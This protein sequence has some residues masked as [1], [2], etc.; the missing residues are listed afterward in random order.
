MTLYQPASLD[1]LRDAVGAIAADGR[2]VEIFGGGSKRGLGCAMAVADRLD[3]VR[4]SGIV[5]YEPAELVLTAK[6][7]TPLAEIEAVLTQ[8]GQMLAFEPPDWR[9]LLSDGA[10]SNGQ[11]SPT[12]GGAIACNLSGSRRIAAGAARDH[13]IGFTGVNGYGQVFKSG[14]RVVK[15]V[16]GYD[17]SKLMAG[18]Y[19]TLAALAEINV[20]VMPRPEASASLAILG[21]SDESAIAALAE[22]LN[23]PH[24][25]SAAAHLPARMSGEAIPHADVPPNT[26][27]TLLRLEGP[28]ASIAFRMTALRGLFAGRGAL[29]ELGQTDS[30][31][32]WRRIGAVAPLLPTVDRLVWRLSLPPS[33]GPAVMAAV[34][35]DL[36]A[37]GYY[38]WG[39]GLIW[40]SV[41]LTREDGGAAVIRAALA[42][43]GGHATLVRA[44]E[45]L[46]AKVAVFEPLPAALAALTR[47]VKESF[48]PR[49]LFN[50]GRLYRDR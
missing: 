19:G 41:P 24:E 3:L 49:H 29:I 11:G 12:L 22:G 40:L 2:P 26:P 38:D 34:R 35:R 10:A 16:T 28:Q 32:L 39:G 21:L 18:S 44:P 50:P 42:S 36:G 27:V 1:E 17:L 6:A 37:I 23:A 15:N 43:L 30:E 8:H 47:R 46:R 45:A 7:A 33:A 31:G 14:G 9:A 5:D 25:V 13:F 20:K 4:L 48:D